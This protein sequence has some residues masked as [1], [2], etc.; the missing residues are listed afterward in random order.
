VEQPAFEIITDP[1]HA[2]RALNE[3]ASLYEQVFAEPPY[4]EGP[5][6][7]APFMERYEKFREMPGF[8]LV[9]A[10]SGGILVGFAL[11]VLLPSDSRWWSSLD[12]GAEFTRE[13][14]H[15]TFAIREVAVA[16]EFRRRGL[17]QTLHAA[18]LDSVEA[19]RVTLAVHPEAKAAAAM[20][21]GLG[22]QQL[23]DMT[24]SR[25]GAPTYRCMLLNLH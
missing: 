11:G 24:P 7:L 6:G 21:E 16:A 25:D 8:R 18:V 2:A 9:L 20:Y 23:G 15:R 4:F 10:R 22:Y 14:G 12:L 17:G 13:D 3:I 1:E 19:D 5:R